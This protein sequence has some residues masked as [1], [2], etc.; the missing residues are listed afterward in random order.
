MGRLYNVKGWLEPYEDSGE[1]L[2]KIIE[3]FSTDL[4]YKGL[5]KNWTLTRAF[6][7]S[8]YVFFGATAKY[9]DIMVEDVVNRIV[10][11]S[12]QI[13]GYFE[14]EDEEDENNW[15]MRIVDSIITKSTLP[16]D[17]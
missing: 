3:E 7:Y 13:D 9:A 6:G 4:I 12:I 15:S 10:S 16:F 11:S 17:S 2:M 14:C 5:V 1:S 8:E